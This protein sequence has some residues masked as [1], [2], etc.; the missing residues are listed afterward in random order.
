MWREKVSPTQEHKKLTQ[1][2][3]LNSAFAE[4]KMISRTHFNSSSVNSWKIS[5]RSRH[6]PLARPRLAALPEAPFDDSL[7]EPLVSQFS[8]RPTFFHVSESIKT[9]A[10]RMIIANISSGP[11]L[12]DEGKIMGMLSESDLIWKASTPVDH[13]IVPPIFLGMFDLLFFLRD[14]PK[15]ESEVQKILSS[16]VGS[17]MTKDV[18]TVPSDALLSNAAKIMMSKNIHSLP[19]ME[20][21]RCIGVISR[22]G[23]LLGLISS[24]SPLLV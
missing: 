18:V 7:K 4:R 21:E 23:V 1:Q 11:V 22:H 6:L 14:Q 9:A 2:L 13:F 20:G 8:S 12:N 15:F 16:T 24:N 10:Q 5:P 17:S 3:L 19:V